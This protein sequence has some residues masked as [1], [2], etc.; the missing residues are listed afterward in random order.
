MPAI[1]KN[2]FLREDVIELTSLVRCDPA[3]AD[4]RDAIVGK[5]FRIGEVFMAG[6]FEDEIGNEYGGLVT[7]TGEIFEFQRSS[8]EG[9]R[10]SI[11]WKNVDDINIL[12]GRFRAAKAALRM[13]TG[14]EV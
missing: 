3:W 12:A 10:G 8:A 6:F 9:G 11:I 14:R 7:A 2:A 1:D 5:G 4:L 13:A